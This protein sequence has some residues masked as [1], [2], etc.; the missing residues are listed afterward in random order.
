MPDQ[1]FLA[2]KEVLQGEHGNLPDIDES[3]RAMIVYTSG[4]TSKPKG[5][6]TTHANI[7][8]QIVSL[9]EAWG[10]VSDDYILN[11]VATS[12]CAWDCK[13]CFYVPY[14]VEQ[15]VR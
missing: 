3:A 15:S 2:L 6:V 10:W 13:M 5:V 12:S 9:V 8:A 7:K 14:G 1:N 4:T 11:G